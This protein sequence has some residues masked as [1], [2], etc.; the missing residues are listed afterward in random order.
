MAGYRILF[1]ICFERVVTVGVPPSLRHYVNVTAN[2]PA[3]ALPDASRITFKDA[4]PD[5]TRGLGWQGTSA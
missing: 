5:P 4:S 1:V 2:D 3:M